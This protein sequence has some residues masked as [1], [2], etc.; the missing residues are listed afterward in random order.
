MT[1]YVLPG[2]GAL[3]LTVLAVLLVRH[4]IR[5]AEA[6]RVAAWQAELTERHY[7]EV[8]HIY[9]QMRGW[10]HDYHN[11]IQ[12]MKAHLALGRLDELE[13]YLGAL[14]K[15]LDEVD[16]L[17]KT[18]NVMLD[19]ILGSKLTLARAR[20]INV[21]ARAAVPD[22]ITIPQVELCVILGN[23]MDNAIE[24]CMRLPEADRFLRVYIG[25][26]QGQFY[27][28]VGNA[29]GAVLREGGRYVSTKGQANHGFGLVRIDRAV[30]RLGGL[31]NRQHEEGVFVTEVM[32]PI[33]R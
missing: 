18:G 28:S 1:A 15:D 25:T 17:L 23:L 13:A 7:E 14:D 24:S 16:V 9:R 19:A 3:V 31:V 20:G 29:S 27:M 12:A 21:N 30:A 4:A 10:R 8:Q 2:I 11:H 6:R 22:G 32:I 33:V 26:Y 5:R